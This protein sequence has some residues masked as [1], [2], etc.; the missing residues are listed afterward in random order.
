M[1]LI[2]GPDL[3][4]GGEELFRLNRCCACD[5]I[6]QNPRPSVEEIGKYY[7][8]DY[9]PFFLAIEDEPHWWSRLSRRYGRYRRCHAV[10]VAAKRAGRLLD[11]GCA[12]GIFLEGMRRF[13]WDVQGVEPS[14]YAARY[15]RERFG[16]PVFEGHLEE[17]P[18]QA[19]SFDVITLWDVLE[20]VHEPREVLARIHEL[21]RAGGLLVMSLP[22]PDSLEARLFGRYWLGWDLPRHLNLFRPAR[23]REHLA[24]Q[25]F[26]VRT[27]RSF[28]SGYSMFLMSLEVY[29]NTRGYNGTA[30]RKLFSLWPFRLISKVYYNGPASWFNLSSVMVVFAV[31]Q[32][33]GNTR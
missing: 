20:H 5:H 19:R 6:Y 11:V 31:R 16:L 1:A 29:L 25:G 12:T 14:S 22:N 24:A 13:G 7:P 10:H 32:P 21:L 33:D 28:T 30:T 17:A 18:L 2:E 8:E 27:I 9:A 3:L 4:H 15:A 23:L 26:E